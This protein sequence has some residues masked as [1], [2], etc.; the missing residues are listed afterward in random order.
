MATTSQL[1]LLRCGNCL[2]RFLVD[3]ADAVSAWSCPACDRQLHLMVRSIPGPPG[4]AASAL[5]ATML[6]APASDRTGPQRGSA[7]AETV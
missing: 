3:D 6:R 2:R 7:A 5:G 1:D 4:R